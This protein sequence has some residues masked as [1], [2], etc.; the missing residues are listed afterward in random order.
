MSTPITP[1]DYVDLSAVA[2]E[3]A[4][5][6]DLGERDIITLSDAAAATMSCCDK[7]DGACWTQM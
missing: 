4:G 1:V 5:D 6:S 3:I 7:T 2:D